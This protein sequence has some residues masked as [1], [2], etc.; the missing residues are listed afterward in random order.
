MS[1]ERPVYF[2]R[3]DSLS[4]I[5]SLLSSSFSS[6][7]LIDS[8]RSALLR[9]PVDAA[10]DAEVLFQVLASRADALLMD[11]TKSERQG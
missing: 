11:A 6:A 1:E 4:L 2:L 7:W 10:H 5:D 8:L 3:S 9:D